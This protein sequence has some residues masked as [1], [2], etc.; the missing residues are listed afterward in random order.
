MWKAADNMRKK[1]TRTADKGDPP[2]WGF[3]DGLKTTQ[4]SNKNHV[5]HCL[6]LVTRSLIGFLI[7]SGR[8]SWA[9]H[10]ARIGG[11]EKCVQDLGKNTRRRH[12]KTLAVDEKIKLHKMLGCKWHGLG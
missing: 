7:K 10:A 2:V 9:G 6:V 5:T 8:M 11:E 12:L 3:G 1:Q 4:M